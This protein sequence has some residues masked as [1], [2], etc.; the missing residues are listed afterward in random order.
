MCSVFAEDGFVLC[1][2]PQ[3]RLCGKCGILEEVDECT[4]DR[5][6]HTWR[7]VVQKKIEILHA[8]REFEQTKEKERG[9]SKKYMINK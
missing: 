4:N 9:K 2:V 8:C 1:V 5:R 3:H 6:D 7:M